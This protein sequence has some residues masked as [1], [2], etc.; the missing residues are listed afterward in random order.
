MLAFIA[1]F[2]VLQNIDNLVLAAAYRWQNVAITWRSNLFIAAFSALFTGLALVGAS[3]AKSGVLVLG[4]DHYAEIVG[5][6]LLLMIGAWMLIGH[7]SKALFP[8]LR[9]P[10]LER[11][12]HTFSTSA[13]E[14]KLGEA[15]L[16]GTALAVD[17]L[18]PSFAFG[19]IN[20]ATPSSGFVLSAL[21]GV[22]S[23]LAV[24]IGQISGAKTRR[25]VHGFSPKL[26]AGCLILSIACFDPGDMTRDRVQ[27][28]TRK[29]T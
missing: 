10:V 23:L 12:P 13:A 25:Y 5:R 2:A 28:L 11:R 18:G 7:F 21:T 16:V 29:L 27:P 1:L 3:C 26:I 24:S 15:L 9:R 22:A 19:L 6:G 8:Q 20:P 14:M 17:N 4:L